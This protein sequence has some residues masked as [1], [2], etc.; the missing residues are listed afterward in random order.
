VK[1]ILTIL[2]AALLVCSAWAN[3]GRAQSEPFYKGKQ[4]KIIVGFTAGGIVDLWA[5]LIAQHLGRQLP[6]NPDIIVQNMAGGGSMAAA[7]H[8]YN[9]AKPDGLTLGLVSTGLYFDQLTGKPQVQFDWAKFSW[10]GSPVRNFEVLSVRPEIVKELPEVIQEIE[11][12]LL[13]QKRE[14]FLGKW[15]EDLRTCF[16]VKVNY[17][18][19]AQLD[20]Y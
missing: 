12:K 6:G 18:L 5:R 1:K 13:H 8:V 15:L 2:V 16:E 9:I 11:S 14:I 4:I 10:I 17:E 19:L 20:L 7:N 3:V